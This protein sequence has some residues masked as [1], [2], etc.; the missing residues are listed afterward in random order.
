LKLLAMTEKG[1]LVALH[2][3]RPLAAIERAL[4]PNLSWTRVAWPPFCRDPWS[5]ELNLPAP[6]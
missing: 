1:V 3:V 6:T 5:A 4:A 2:P